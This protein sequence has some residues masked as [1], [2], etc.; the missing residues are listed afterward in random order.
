MKIYQLTQLG[1]RLARNTSTPDTPNWRALYALDRLGYGTPDQIAI[2]AG[3]EE[4]EAA[5]AL[6]IL[7]RKNLVEEH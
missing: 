3:L 4:N 1:H 7:K 2:Q 5:S 6:M